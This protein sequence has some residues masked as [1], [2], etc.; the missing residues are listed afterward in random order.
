MK[1]KICKTC[2]YCYK[3]GFCTYHLSYW[4]PTH[5]CPMWTDETLEVDYNFLYHRCKDYIEICEMYNNYEKLKKEYPEE[6]KWESTCNYDF[7]LQCCL[8][9][10]KRELSRWTLKK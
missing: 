4:D 10:M 9:D 5:T 2:S 1:T 8:N 3:D 7:F 6:M